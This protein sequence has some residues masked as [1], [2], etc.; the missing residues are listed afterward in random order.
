MRFT[1]EHA[2]LRETTMKFV[3][4]EINPHCDAWE[5][6]GIFPAHTIMK[7]AGDIGLL[8]IT[9]PEAYGGSGLDYS[10][11]MVSAE[12]LGFSRA[13]GVSSRSSGASVR[14]R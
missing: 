14:S 4:T 6:E 7:K 1:E 2:M 11:Q 8:G 9:K 5:E 12:A 13:G 3:E 10:Y